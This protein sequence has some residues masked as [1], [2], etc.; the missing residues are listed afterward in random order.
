[1]IYLGC[2]LSNPSSLIDKQIN[3]II[4][5]IFYKGPNLDNL[6]RLCSFDL[7][8]LREVKPASMFIPSPIK[9]V[10][11]NFKDY[12]FEEDI[13]YKI[14]FEDENISN[15]FVDSK[16]SKVYYVEVC[17]N[18]RNIVDN[19]PS[20]ESVCIGS[21]DFNSDISEVREITY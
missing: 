19:S 9:I 10:K 3:P 1:M 6:Q 15:Y 18:L 12:S 13:V 16:T 7:Q 14:S 4:K 11:F 17:R 20:I 8:V 21:R 5:E 2:Y